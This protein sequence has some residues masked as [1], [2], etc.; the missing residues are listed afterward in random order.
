ML[1]EISDLN[2]WFFEETATGGASRQ[3]VLHDISLQTD[4]RRTLALVGESG[5]GKSV[6]ALSIL[7]LLEESSDVRTE[8]TI[9]F[10]GQ[11]LLT[12][13]RRAIRKIRGNDIAMIFQEPM[14]SLNPLYTVGNQMVEPLMLHQKMSKAEAEKEAVRLLD[15][16]GI[17]EPESRLRVY[18]ASTLGRPATAGNDRHGPG[19]STEAADRR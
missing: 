6:T 14:S 19:L 1:L 17:T 4:V 9:R 13:S 5:S 11:N 10:G 12:L 7:R 8:G 3:Q 16:T 15:R 2:L 18:P